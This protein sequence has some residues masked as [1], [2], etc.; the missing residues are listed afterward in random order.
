MRTLALALLSTLAAPAWAGV[1]V[2]STLGIGSGVFVF[3]FTG[4]AAPVGTSVGFRPTL[5]LYFDDVLLQVHALDT[6]DMLF[7]EQIFLGA[8]LYFDL[9]DAPTRNG[10]KPVLAPGA[11]VDLMGDPFFLILTGEARLGLEMQGPAGVSFAV[12]PAL[13][14]AVGD[15]DTDLVTGGT[16]QFS[17]FFGRGGGGSSS[18]GQ[19]PLDPFGESNP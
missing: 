14:I 17:G 13:G 7:D 16:L 6:L 8:N 15:I 3:D 12:V 11:G 10:W 18:R 4:T 2:G 5:D 19:A 9:G 1:G